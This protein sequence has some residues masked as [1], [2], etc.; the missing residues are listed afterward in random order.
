MKNYR[1][2]RDCLKRRRNLRSL[3]SLRDFRP[4]PEGGLSKVGE[5]GW[6]E[7]EG[8]LGEEG[9]LRES[10]MT[11]GLLSSTTKEATGRTGDRGSLSESAR[12]KSECQLL[13]VT[14]QR[15]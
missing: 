14:W 3:T 5:E 10:D 7:G 12:R 13:E 9:Q 4:L 2:E 15:T 1:L 6:L 8:W 11:P